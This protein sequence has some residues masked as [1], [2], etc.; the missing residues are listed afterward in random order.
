MSASLIIGASVP[1]PAAFAARWQPNFMVFRFPM[2]PPEGLANRPVAFR[3]SIDITQ[4]RGRGNVWYLDLTN[5]NDSNTGASWSQAKRTI[6]TGIHQNASVVSGDVVY[7][8]GG[9]AED[10]FLG[11]FS[12]SLTL[13]GV[14]Q[15]I[16][17]NS[18]TFGS[19]TDEGSGAYSCACTQ[20][21]DVRPMDIAAAWPGGEYRCLLQRTSLAT[22][23]ATAGSYWLDDANDKLYVKLYTP[24]APT[25]AN[26]WVGDSSGGITL[27][28]GVDLYAENIIFEGGYAG[29][30]QANSNSNSRIYASRC[31]FRYC[32]MN[33]IEI[34]SPS[35]CWIQD[36]HAYGNGGDGFSYNVAGNYL[37]ER[38]SGRYNGGINN[39]SSQGS[40]SHTDCNVIRIACEH[41]K[42]VG[43]C[44][45]DVNT[46][47]AWNLGVLC[48]ES[49]A[50]ASASN[51]D[52]FNNANQ[53]CDECESYGSTYSVRQ[54]A[55][56]AYLHN[57][58]FK[59]QVVT[60]ASADNLL[61]Y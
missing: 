2:P 5:G 30:R 27:N 20:S 22:V 28:T 35:E 45:A 43:Q 10:A 3:S 18:F 11:N 17:R 39:D 42:N 34:T 32:R 46:C 33:G 1:P 40:T 56:N 15:P 59:S 41:Y 9:P 48:H 37:E 61:F 16:F 51:A 26:L 29:I 14:D 38:C 60:V 50:V 24:A 49:L 6:W 55:G 31:T 44:I 57:P 53:W 54:T 36:C 19:W 47:H 12:K 25:T 58:H 13:I 23:Q 7:I 21:T 8:K 4:K 52:F